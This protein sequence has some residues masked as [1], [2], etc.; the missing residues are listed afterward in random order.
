M[1]SVQQ[2]K[3]PQASARNY[4]IDKYYYHNP[5]ISPYL[6]LTRWSGAN[7]INNYYRYV[8]P[9]VERRAA[10]PQR[11][12]TGAFSSP[13]QSYPIT[14]PVHTPVQ[15]TVPGSFHGN[16]PYFNNYY[17]NFGGLKR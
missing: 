12:G 3:R 11:P 15:Q 9:E 8:L 14:G 4:I 1:Q 5:N 7:S 16:V 13:T 10:A 17:N 6:N 2:Y